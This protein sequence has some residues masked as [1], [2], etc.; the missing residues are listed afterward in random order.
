MYQ[1]TE[2][3]DIRHHTIYTPLRLG[4]QGW[5]GTGKTFAA[6]TFPNILVL[7][8]DGKL[9]GVRRHPLF[10]DK[11]IL[12]VPFYDSAFCAELAD[13]L[14]QRKNSPSDAVN[15]RDP[16]R[17]WLKTEGKKLDRE[18]IVFFDSWT[19]W[20]RSMDQ[21]IALEPVISEKSNK[22]DDRAPWAAKLK[23][24]SEVYDDLSSLPCG[25]IVSFHEFRSQGVK[26]E[27]IDKVRPLQS[28]QFQA[29]IP[30]IFSNYFR[31]HAYSGVD[32]IS[33][34]G[35]TLTAAQYTDPKGRTKYTEFVWQTISDDDT[36]IICA[37]PDMPAYVPAHW[38]SLKNFS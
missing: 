18:Q 13:K 3:R 32:S 26:G 30:S 9:D 33:K 20:Q 25:L 11:V 19:A 16:F 29:Q 22:I 7:D 17:Y 1:P 35:S 37:Y 5:S 27:L 21:Q 34:I 36:D 28:G 8:W 24:S 10:K 38:Q 14:K 31:Q 6:C 12:S 2:A 15:R 4:I 23:F